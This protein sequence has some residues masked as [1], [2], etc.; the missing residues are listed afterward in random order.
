MSNT[1]NRKE[2]SSKLI[3]ILIILLGLIFVT[4]T[5]LETRDLS[6]E[7]AVQIQ[8]LTA[9]VEALQAE[10]VELTTQLSE[11]NDKLALCDAALQEAWN[12]IQFLKDGYMAE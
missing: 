10:N 5:L 2:G 6:S 11:A 4:I 12:A 8:T 1:E 7:Q 3:L 9:Q